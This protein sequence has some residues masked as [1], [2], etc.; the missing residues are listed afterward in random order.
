MPEERTRAGR[1]PT[2]R[3]TV[4]WRPQRLRGVSR[5]RRW[6]QAGR[7]HAVRSAGVGRSAGSAAAAPERRR[8]AAAGR[9]Q[10]ARWHRC[11]LRTSIPWARLPKAIRLRDGQAAGVFGRLLRALLDR[12]GRANAIDF[13]CCP[14]TAPPW[15]RKGGRTHRPEPDRP[16]QAG[17]QAPRPRG[18]ERRPARAPAQPRERPRQPALRALARRRAGAWASCTPTKATATAVAAAPIA[19]GACWPGQLA[20]RDR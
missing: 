10:G 8:P 20:L 3:N 5:R 15:R 16:R 13:G 4:G 1:S 19:S 18:R 17:Q 9:P 2:R 7:P 6:P 12:L 11:M 14:W